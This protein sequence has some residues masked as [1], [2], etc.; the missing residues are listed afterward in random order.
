MAP[1]CSP[2][3]YRQNAI[4]TSTASSIDAQEAQ[5]DRLLHST[6]RLEASSRRLDH[7][8]R[9]ANETETLGAD[10]LT[11]LHKQRG[12]IEDTK[13]KLAEGEGYVNKSLKTLK[14]MGKWYYLNLFVWI[15]LIEGGN[16]R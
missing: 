15:M 7:S 10:I 2:S 9:I 1:S 6:A 4:T 3:A 5:R 13:A 16:S 12:Q 8:H 14:D 11:E